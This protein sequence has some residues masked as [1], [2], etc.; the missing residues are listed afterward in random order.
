MSKATMTTLY[1]ESREVP[2]E[3]NLSGLITSTLQNTCSLP[4]LL[5]LRNNTMRTCRETG[6][7]K[8]VNLHRSGE[9]RL[10]ATQAAVALLLQFAWT[11]M[12]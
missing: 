4:V 11:S 2:L 6:Y 7:T 9:K 12:S 5:R 3:A 10:R 1:A 8:E